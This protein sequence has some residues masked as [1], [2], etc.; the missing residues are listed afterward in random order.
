MNLPTDEDFCRCAELIEQADGVLIAAG[1]GLGV[2]SGL[3]DFRSPRGFW[4]SY[5]A[6]GRAC[7]AFEQIANP[8]AF[9][10]D[11]EQAWGFYG[12]RL[13]L[14]RAT[15]PHAGFSILRDL[16]ASMP[17]GG[18]V[19]TS[20]VDGQFAKAGF[21]ASRICEC[22]GSIHHLQ[23]MQGCC[24]RI[25]SADELV[26]DVDEATCRLRSPLPRCPQCGALARP[27]ILMFDDWNWL[28]QRSAAQERRLQRWL[29]D[30]ERLLVIEIGAGTRVSTVRRLSELVGGV[31]IRINPDE[32]DLGAASGL[33][34]ACNGL[35][36]L[37]GIAAAYWRHR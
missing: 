1:A 13:N 30:T 17:A 20:N 12:H 22:H 34:L 3:P 27:N 15:Q 8:A 18:F 31:L 14:Y 16:V 24:D 29:G 19:F 32:P 21:D 35:F 28:E 2:D 10:R 23:C 26:V 36:A 9:A 25:W 5:P 37:H 11:A 6:L 7:M 33:S 4:R